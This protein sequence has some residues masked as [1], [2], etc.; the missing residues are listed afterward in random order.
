MTS[1]FPVGA[2]QSPWR[3]PSHGEKALVSYLSELRGSFFSEDPNYR[4]RDWDNYRTSLDRHFARLDSFLSGEGTR[5]QNLVLGNVQSGKTGHLLAN[6]CWARDSGFH[7]VVVFSGDKNPLNEQT[8]KR[9]SK[10][11]KEYAFV[12]K[13]LTEKSSGFNEKAEQVQGNIA[14]RVRDASALI[15]VLVLIKKK[16]RIS[17]LKRMI[18]GFQDRYGDSLRVLILDDEADQAG[19]DTT[20]SSR[21]PHSRR[22]GGGRTPSARQSIH[23]SM[24]L[25]RDA[26]RGR[27]IYLSYTATPQALLHGELENFLQPQFCSTVPSGPSY[28]GIN[29]LAEAPGALV[30]IESFDEEGLLDGDELNALALEHAFGEFLVTSWLHER[31]HSVFHESTFGPG[32]RCSQTSIQ[33]LIHP[34]GRQIDHRIYFDWIQNLRSEWLG[35]MRSD[36]NRDRFVAEL[37]TP[38]WLSVLDR[39]GS[40]EKVELLTDEGRGDALNH[41]YELL[42][43]SNDLR[44]LL[45][46]SNGRQLLS[47]TGDEGNLIPTEMPEWQGP[48]AW[49]LVGGN[50][51]GRGL[52]IPHLTTTLF[53]RNPQHPNFD[54][55]VQQ[56]RFCGYRGSYLR[57]IRVFAPSGIVRDYRDAVI[58]D[59]MARV[60]AALWD[61]EGRDLLVNPPLSRFV[62]P[63][64]TRY[65]PTR[66]SVVSGY[67]VTANSS[68]TSGFFSLRHICSPMIFRHNARLLLDFKGL[69]NG[70]TQDRVTSFELNRE[71]LYE[72]LTGWL[73]EPL[74]SSDFATFL[75]LLTYPQTAGGFGGDQF[76]LC[77]D[78]EIVEASTENDLE[79]LLDDAAKLYRRSVEPKFSQSDWEQPPNDFDFSEFK[80][81]AVVGESE[82]TVQRFFADK[83]MVHARVFA[84]HSKELSHRAPSVR[85]NDNLAG[86]PD[87]IGISLI[88]WVPSSDF[89]YWVHEQAID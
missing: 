47:N 60:R 66:R 5:V 30:S 34:S 68:T 31:H 32:S 24:R 70:V 49:I 17:A 22:R 53:L 6:I 67:V 18:E 77:V 37:F 48:R 55:S 75:E 81:V 71:T 87:A 16:E 80:I 57:L 78:N 73:A 64:N 62:A 88:G 29:E 50:I 63:A 4:D 33:M 41:V 54:T 82:R 51:L 39:L 58:I 25:L 7:L 69:S 12:E 2:S 40:T 10:Q 59:D 23:D 11:L 1:Q 3:P 36:L 84:L 13:V 79:E 86:P 9:I 56:M 26:I 38:I 15:P 89:Q 52:T 35:A 21:G 28:V 42:N 61:V 83:V 85:V 43:S 14:E 46:N 74:D 45:V 20:A 76:M 72:L 65:S 44:L 27:C 8:Y 19:P